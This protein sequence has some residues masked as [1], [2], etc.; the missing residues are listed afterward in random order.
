MR[1][2]GGRLLGAGRREERR[3][4]G[5][6]AGDRGK[7]NARAPPS[8]TQIRT[9]PASGQPNMQ[10]PDFTRNMQLHLFLTKSQQKKTKI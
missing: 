4:T 9:R 5:R 10:L 3:R 1:G 8:P 6:Q 2:S 7:H